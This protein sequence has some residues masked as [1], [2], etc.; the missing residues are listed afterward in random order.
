MFEISIKIFNVVVWTM[1][2]AYM[3]RMCASGVI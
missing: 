1:N 3:I 2:A